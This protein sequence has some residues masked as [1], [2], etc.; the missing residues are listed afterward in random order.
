MRDSDPVIKKR[1]QEYGM[2]MLI[3]SAGFGISE[4][5]SRIGDNIRTVIS[6]EMGD[7][8]KYMDVLL[9]DTDPAGAG[10]RAEDWL[11]WRGIFWS[12]RQ[13]WH[14]GQR[15]TSRGERPSLKYAKRSMK[16]K[17]EKEVKFTYT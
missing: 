10:L 7:K 14:S 11:L 16:T 3:T 1:A 15:M 6:L 13:R 2:Y 5:Q 12:F 8:F 4:I 9:A 17:V